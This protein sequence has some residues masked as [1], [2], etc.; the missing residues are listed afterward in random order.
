MNFFSILSLGAT[1]F[2]AIEGV[3]SNLAS[4]QPVTVPEIR[5]Y[6]GGHHIAI[7]LTIKPLP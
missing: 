2:S 3:L 6:V 7:D 1:I 4:G 5:T